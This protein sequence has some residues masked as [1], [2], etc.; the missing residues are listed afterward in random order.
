M[1]NKT[2]IL[3]PA[4]SLNA[5]YAAMANG[6]DA[7]YLGGK[8]FGARANASNFTLEEIKELIKY[9]HIRD[10]KVYVT[11]N[12]VLFEKEFFDALAFVQDLYLSDVDAIIIQDL[13]LAMVIREKFPDLA[14]HAST[15]MNIHNIS[16]AKIVQELG[17]KR[18]VLPREMNI[19]TIKEIKKQVAI[20]LEVF[21]HGA[22]CVSYSGNCY[23]SSF[24][25]KRSGN[26]GQCA[27]PCRLPYRLADQEKYWLSPKELYTI[28]NIKQLQALGI[29]SFKIEGRMKRPE[30]VAQ[31][32]Q[33]YRKAVNHE[34][35]SITQEDRRLRTIFNRDWTKGFLFK[36]ENKNFSNVEQ[37]N[38]V[39][40]IIGKVIST[41][42]DKVNVKLL[43]PLTYGD[44]I[45]LVGKVTDAV[46]I[47]QMYV[48]NRL[49]KEA[50][51]NDVV[52]I[53]T[54]MVGLEDAKV[55][56]TTD[57]KQIDELANTYKNDPYKIDI[58]GVCYVEQ[59]Q[60]IFSITDQIHTVSQICLDK[61]EVANSNQIEKI[62]E[63][64]GKT[65]NTIFQFKD[66]QVR[67]NFFLP[68]KSINQL[69]RDALTSLE[70]LRSIKYPN[71]QVRELPEEK[72]NHEEELVGIKVK[73]HN[74]TQ[75][76]SAIRFP[77]KAIYVTDIALYNKYQEIPNVY[78]HLPRNNQKSAQ[79]KLITTDLSLLSNNISSVY[80]NV[81]NHFSVRQME[82]FGAKTV[83]LSVELSFNQ[84]KDL[85]QSYVHDYGSVPSLEMMVY[86]RHELMT[87]AYC[88]LNKALGKEN[89]YCGECLKSQY[90]L[91]D[92]LGYDFPLIRDEECNL[93]LL[94]TK[95]LHLLPYIN[96]I[97]DAG[98]K[99]LL[100]DFTLETELE[101]EQIMRM[102]FAALQN[103]TINQ[104]EIKEVINGNWTFGHFKEEII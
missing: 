69:R 40:I 102:Y 32:V 7:V 100:L 16:M 63:Q 26:R 33:S 88:P 65:A 11:V 10:K 86:G 41:Y 93:I 85:I 6:A 3:A 35:F 81:T 20:E 5:F 73:V 101:M 76:Q 66:L 27:Q 31:V 8:A 78:Y 94:N 13:G 64:L 58:E 59:G 90:Y 79:G 72:Q 83:G 9:A 92:R 82:K 22:L 2:E 39:G 1:T 67:D 37:Q 104:E 77:I 70:N 29:T 4:G 23:F 54:H 98:I 18:I 47:N 84:I 49:V 91:T 15:Q 68:I 12:T 103:E 44:S 25:G 80:T 74:E 21:V 34:P 57:K 19:D 48:A 52:T 45:R 53:K 95:R 60:V 50:N 38:H 43:S 61:P 36:E 46:T 51:A 28:D 96:D 56:L 89:K 42:Q 87:M 14:L 17:F 71:R 55:Y 62:K 24:I 75:L 97:I 30:Y 99:N